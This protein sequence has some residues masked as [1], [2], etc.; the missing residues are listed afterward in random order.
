M[1]REKKKA[2]G[3]FTGILFIIIGIGLLWWNE[4]NNVKNIKTTAELE[5][6]YVDVKSD[7]ISPKNEGKLV[8]V[9]GK[10]INDAELVDDKFNI[11]IKTPLM[12]RIVEVYQWEEKEESDDNDNK[13]YI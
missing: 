1:K 5:D 6:N 7:S 11:T 10:L 8:A 9:S 2:A 13:K 3:P 4:G 12:K